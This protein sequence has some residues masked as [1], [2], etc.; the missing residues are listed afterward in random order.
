MLE[1]V[2][3]ASNLDAEFQHQLAEVGH[4]PLATPGELGSLLSGK[5]H[6]MLT[7]WSSHRLITRTIPRSN[8]LLTVSWPPFIS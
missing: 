4:V 1:K 7:L 6:N 5:S 2:T 8:A 3:L